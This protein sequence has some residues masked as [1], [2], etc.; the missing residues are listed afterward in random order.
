MSQLAPMGYERSLYQAGE[1]LC[2]APL[3]DRLKQ[4]KDLLEKE[5]ADVNAAMAALAKH[6]DVAETIE[7]ISRL[8][9]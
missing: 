6:P 5:L 1:G 7:A 2:C 8:G 4:R 3:S 9:V